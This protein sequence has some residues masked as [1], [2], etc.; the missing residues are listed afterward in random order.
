MLP[1]RLILIFSI[2]RLVRVTVLVRSE[3]MQARAIVHQNVLQLRS[4]CIL[5][6]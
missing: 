3:A 6:R 5:L 2:L 4:S 1:V